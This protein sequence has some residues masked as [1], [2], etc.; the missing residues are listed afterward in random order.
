MSADYYR[1]QSEAYVFYHYCERM[2]HSFLKLITNVKR[3]L[4]SLLAPNS[5]RI[6]I[7]CL[8]VLLSV[9]DLCKGQ[10][11]SSE[12][13][14]FISSAGEVDDFD[15]QQ[16]ILDSAMKMARVSKGGLDKYL[17]DITSTRGYSFLLHRM[18]V[19]ALDQYFLSLRFKE[20]AD[21][22]DYQLTY[23]LFGIYA[24]IAN[25]LLDASLFQE[26]IPYYD[27]AI[28]QGEKLLLMEEDSAYYKED[29]ENLLDFRIY[30]AQ[31]LKSIGKPDLAISQLKE[32]LPVCESLDNPYSCFQVL[33][34]IGQMVEDVRESRSYHLKSLRIRG[35]DAMYQGI[36]LHN[37]GNTYFDEGN[38]GQALFY[39]DSAIQIKRVVFDSTKHARSLFY[40]YMDRGEVY[41]ALELYDSAINDWQTALSLNYDF[42][43]LPELFEIYGFLRDAY[44][45]NNKSLSRAYD[46][47]FKT[48]QSNYRQSAEVIRVSNESEAIRDLLKSIEIKDKKKSWLS[49]YLLFGISGVLFLGLVAYYWL[50]KRRSRR[51]KVLFSKLGGILMDDS[52]SS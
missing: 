14:D 47:L 11:S 41:Y 26:S 24:N 52:E 20:F 19:E 36:E 12:I 22:S 27:S 9:C 40:S 33:N 18:N 46:D 35:L 13:E 44:K 45:H 31:A 15:T 28:I 2:R 1:V 8:V 3:S 25:I 4:P 37:I 30:R 43:N 5:W 42:K 39:I 16:S 23:S 7:L 29:L 17:M 49:D 51:K 38:L 34:N 21:L 48:Y 10:A 50:S 32:L 6:S